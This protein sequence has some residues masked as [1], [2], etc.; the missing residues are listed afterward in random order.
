MD[1][2]WQRSKFEVPLVESSTSIWTYVNDNCSEF[3]NPFYSCVKQ[4]LEPSCDLSSIKFWHEHFLAWA[5][6]AT[7]ETT[8][9]TLRPF[10]NRAEILIKTLNDCDYD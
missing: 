6:V 7:H 3:L 9:D 1:N 5:E 8:I 10:D 2:E 4:R